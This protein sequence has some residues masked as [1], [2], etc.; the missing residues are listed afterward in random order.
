MLF[1]DISP[2]SH[3]SGITAVIGISFSFLLTGIV[4]K[5]A[6]K[7]RSKMMLYFA[8]AAVIMSEPWWP[9]CFGY[10][11]WLLTKNITSYEIYMIT[12]N[13]L[14]PFAVMAWIQIYAQIITPKRKKI[15]MIISIIY[16]VIYWIYFFSVLFWLPGAPVHELLGVIDL[17]YHPFDI[18]YMGYILFFHFSTLFL[19][20]GTGFEFAL[21]TMK[22]KGRRYKIQGSFMLSGWLCYCGATIID[23]AFQLNDVALV[24]IRFII[25]FS[26]LL[27]YIGFIFPLWI[28]KL[29]N[30]QDDPAEEQFL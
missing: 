19:T 26:G 4:L 16:S 20:L 2:L 10:I 14:L 1:V 12:A 22:L 25:T 11:Y 5:K 24:L 8:I 29:F 3:I 27:F 7:D 13:L 18:R 21:N 15:L 17:P 28:R 9:Y 23:S 6:I 30:I